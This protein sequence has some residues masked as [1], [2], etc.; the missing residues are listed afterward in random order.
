MRW[1]LELWR[2]GRERVLP[3]FIPISIHTFSSSTFFMSQFGDWSSLGSVP[4][5]R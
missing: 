1:D 5:S 2:D 4:D 3:Q